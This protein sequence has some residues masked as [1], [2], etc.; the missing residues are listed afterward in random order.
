VGVYYFKNCFD[1]A[2][3]GKDNLAT[4]DVRD[5]TASH[6]HVDRGP[7]H[8]VKHHDDLFSWKKYNNYLHTHETLHN[9]M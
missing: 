2:F 9:T 7:M 6:E 4:V 3:S 1:F 8:V 5:T